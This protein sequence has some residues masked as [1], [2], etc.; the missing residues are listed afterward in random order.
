MAFPEN[1]IYKL[2]NHSF[3]KELDCIKTVG[4]TF[5]PLDPGNKDY[6]KYLEW[7]SEGGVAE[8]AD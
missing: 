4:N 6:Q 2:V 7:V 3:S 1:P 8:A 5:I